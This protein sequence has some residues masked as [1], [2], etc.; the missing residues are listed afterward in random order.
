MFFCMC[1][2]FSFFFACSEQSSSNDF[3]SWENLD[4]EECVPQGKV[5]QRGHKKEEDSC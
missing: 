3:F 5:G 2:R 4:Q 1:I